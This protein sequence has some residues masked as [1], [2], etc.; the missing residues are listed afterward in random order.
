MRVWAVSLVSLVPT[1][2]RGPFDIYVMQAAMCVRAPTEALA[3]RHAKLVALL[4]DG[5]M[6]TMG[7][8]TEVKQ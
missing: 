3:V 5:W 7:S 1:D 2:G 8:A 4:E 6:A